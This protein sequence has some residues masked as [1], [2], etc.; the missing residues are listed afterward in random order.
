[1]S[2]TTLE[3]LSGERVGNPV[4]AA[5]AEGVDVPLVTARDVA[6]S[7]QVNSVAADQRFKGKMVQVSGVVKSINTNF[8]GDPVVIMDG[9]LDRRSKVRFRFDQSQAAAVA[10]LVPGQKAV[11]GCIGDG[12]TMKHPRFTTCFI[13]RAS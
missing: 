7:Y 12:D 4:I 13:V 2:K 1:M 9:G 3:Y 11:F 8:T 6:Q 5:M 10:Q